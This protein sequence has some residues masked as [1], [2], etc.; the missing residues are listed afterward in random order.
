M[1][2]KDLCLCLSIINFTFIEEVKD[3]KKPEL[4]TNETVKQPTPPPV[5]RFYIAKFPN[6]IHYNYVCFS[7]QILRKKEGQ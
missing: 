6:S 3:E 4:K 7:S 1:L 5:K 2:F